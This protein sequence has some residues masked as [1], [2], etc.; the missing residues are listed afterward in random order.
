[1]STLFWLV[2]VA[3]ISFFLTMKMYRSF[4]A[5]LGVYVGL[6]MNTKLH[7]N[8]PISIVTMIV[9]YFFVAYLTNGKTRR[10]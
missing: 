1:M 7:V 2:G 6:W 8:A 5:G 9:I 4:A 10:G 3:F